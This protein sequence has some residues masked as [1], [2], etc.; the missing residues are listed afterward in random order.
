MK[1]KKRTYITAIFVAMFIAISWH[2][3]P[4][5]HGQHTHTDSQHKNHGNK[6]QQSNMKGHEDSHYDLHFIDSMIMHHQGAIQMSKLVETKGDHAR[7]KAFARRVIDDQ[8]KDIKE[9]ENYRSKYYAGKEKMEGMN[10]PDMSKEEMRKKMEESMK[11]LQSSSGHDF[12][13]NFVSIMTEHHQDGI[14]MAKD[15]VAKAEHAEIKRFAQ[16]VVTKQQK[17]ITEMN[18]MQKMLKAMHHKH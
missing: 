16:K 8:Q 13:H 11:A 15:A 14:K 5:V 18:T 10:M 1:T 3:P 17:E 9:L 6:G 4:M 2:E 7:V 12:D